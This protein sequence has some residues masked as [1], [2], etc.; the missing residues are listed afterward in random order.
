MGFGI[1]KKIVNVNIKKNLL[2]FYLRKFFLGYEN[3]N[4]FLQKLDKNSV[5]YILKKNKV[6]IG[7]NCD[8]ETGLVFHNCTDF[9]NLIIGNKC[10]IGKNSFFD[11]RDKIEI[12]DNVV[13]SM[14]CTFITHIDMTPSPLNLLYPQKKAPIIIKNG[15]YIGARST[16][17]MGVTIGECSFI[18]A[19]S[20]V[21]QDVEPYTM[22][23][24]VPAKVIK[25]LDIKNG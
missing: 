22:V 2:V 7:V 1:R 21:T 13:I 6:K 9:S 5:I 10:H 3:T 24:G 14:Q 8:I 25:K 23:G 4:L 20:L 18:A 16:I 11:L 19:G 17:L 12:A 15:C